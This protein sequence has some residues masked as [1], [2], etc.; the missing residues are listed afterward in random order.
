MLFRS[1]DHVY[2]FLEMPQSAHATALGGTQVAMNTYD[3][4]QIF[5]N[6][7][8]ITDTA[9]N[10]IALNITPYTSGIKYGT[11]A[12]AYH[13][14]NIGTVAFGLQFINYGSFDWIDENN[15]DMGTFNAS[16]YAFYLTYSKVLTPQITLAATVKPIIS[17]FETYNSFGIAMDL[18]AMYRSKN[19][20]FTAAATI[21]N[22]GS[23]ISTYDGKHESLPTDIKMGLSYQPEH[24]PF[25][26]SLTL[27]D[28]TKWDLSTDSDNKIS[29]ADNALRHAIIGFELVPFKNFY[30][31]MGYNHR[32][33]KEM[34]TSDKKGS[35][36]LSWGFGLKIYK[37]N[38][39]YGSAR[40]HL[41]GSSN[42][43]SISTNLSSFL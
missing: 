21:K 9:H 38:I 22:F 32:I 24:A 33:R 13:L 11:A 43:I 29:F 35:A 19:R 1:G 2:D 30:V 36:G 15:V 18:G 28:L 27:K 31:G 10:N 39:A 26:I 3:I 37:F 23:Q 7:A 4:S 34:V 14:E 6:P 5:Q 8:S 12:Y 40:Y 16:E 20:R 17:K 25:R 41:G 42:S